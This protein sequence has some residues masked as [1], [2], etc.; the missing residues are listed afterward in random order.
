MLFFHAKY[1]GACKFIVFYNE[2]ILDCTPGDDDSGNVLRSL[3]AAAQIRLFGKLKLRNCAR[4]GN[5][6]GFSFGQVRRDRTA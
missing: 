6:A 4:A 3:D 2:P 5:R 1:P